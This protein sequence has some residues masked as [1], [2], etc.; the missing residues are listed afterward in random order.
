[1]ELQNFGKNRNPEIMEFL[2]NSEIPLGY[3]HT[4]ILNEKGLYMYIHMLL[5]F[6]AILI[7]MLLLQHNK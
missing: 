3:I 6:L 1:M 4:Y 5:Y 2:Y 7:Q